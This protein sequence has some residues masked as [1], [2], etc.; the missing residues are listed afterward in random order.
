VD[1]RGVYGGVEFGLEK[2]AF[3]RMAPQRAGI[4]PQTPL[5]K[6]MARIVCDME[7]ISDPSDIYI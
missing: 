6:V 1:G 2:F 7:A 5:E 4:L 3:A